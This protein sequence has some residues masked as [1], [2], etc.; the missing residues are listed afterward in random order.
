MGKH[1]ATVNLTGHNG[2][3]GNAKPLVRASCPKKHKKKGK[4]GKRHAY[5]L[6]KPSP[7]FGY[8]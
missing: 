2:K 7:A 3:A 1:R 5:R 8:Q 6:P 4:A